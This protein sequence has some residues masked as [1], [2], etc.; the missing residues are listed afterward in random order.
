MRKMRMSKAL[1]EKMKMPEG[2]EVSVRRD[3]GETLITIT[4]SKPWMLG[5][6]TPVVVVE[7]ISGCFT[8]DR[9]EPRP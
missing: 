8:L 4:L 5:G 6:H 3:N 1:L 9:I 2:T 7:G